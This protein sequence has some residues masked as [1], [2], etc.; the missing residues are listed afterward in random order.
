MSTAAN[1]E[2][3]Q[4][5]SDFRAAVANFAEAA[6]KLLDESDMELRRAAQW[7][8]QDQPLY[9][10]REVQKAIDAVALARNEL[11]RA[12]QALLDGQ[13][14]TCFQQKK[15]LEAARQRQRRAEEKLEVTRQCAG[16][17]QKHASE[18]ASRMSQFREL[19]AADVPRA[20]ALLGRMVQSL[21]A[22][23][24]IEAPV[25]VRPAGASAGGI[26]GG[27]VGGGETSAPGEVAD[28]PGGD[29]AAKP[30]PPERQAAAD[31]ELPREGGDSADAVK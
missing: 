14:P 7:V 8:T 28:T 2:S 19:L 30:A 18:Y 1:V 4:A 29:Q 16:R 24:S 20:M 22:Y 15:A 11:E 10:R 6:N 21:E 31:R 13:R 27:G 23:A 17:I 5:L 26:A 12:Q 9:W 25:F 3:I